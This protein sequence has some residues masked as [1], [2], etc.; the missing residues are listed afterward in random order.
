M[1]GSH[2]DTFSA[3]TISGTATTDNNN[4]DNSSYDYVHDNGIWSRVEEIRARR[5][6]QLKNQ[7]MEQF[8]EAKQEKKAHALS[9]SKAARQAKIDG[10]RAASTQ[11]NTDNIKHMV[12][13][14]DLDLQHK[15]KQQQQ[16]ISAK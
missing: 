4:D 13:V 11:N 15:Q 5:I 14:I 9:L 7:V 6:K 2:S 16:P 1:I 3:G 12:K 10:L 8:Q